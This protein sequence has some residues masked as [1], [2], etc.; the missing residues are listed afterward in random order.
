MCSSP[1]PLPHYQQFKLSTVSLTSLSGCCTDYHSGL[2]WRPL[3][4][5]WASSMVWGQMTWV[6]LLSLGHSK[7]INKHLRALASMCSSVKWGEQFLLE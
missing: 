1:G 6:S 5:L 7:Q 3:S 4:L 2:S